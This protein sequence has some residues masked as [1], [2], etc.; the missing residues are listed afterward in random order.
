MNKK[1]L[2][3]AIGVNLTATAQAETPTLEQMWQMIQ[4]QQAEIAELKSQLKE[5]EV[6]T[7]AT[8]TAV[9]QIALAPAAASKTTFRWLRRGTL[10][11]S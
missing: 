9:E 4:N 2:A 10:Q 6:I 11:Q 7:E 5:T 8:I 1:L 3:L